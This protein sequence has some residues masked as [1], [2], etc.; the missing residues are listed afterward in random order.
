[1]IGFSRYDF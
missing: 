1:Q